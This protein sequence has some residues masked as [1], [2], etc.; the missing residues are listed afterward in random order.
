MIVLLGRGDHPTDGVRDYCRLLGQALAARGYELHVVRMPWPQTGWFR[1]LG[2][3]WGESER[4]NRQQVL[5]QYTAL[6]WSRRGFPLRLLTVLGLLR[7]RRIRTA[8]VFHDPEPY[9]GRR[10]VDRM[11]RF[12]Q[13][14]VMRSGYRF[15]DK[16]IITVAPER[17]SWLPLSHS[18]AAFI[19]V[20]SNIP[21][22]PASH[23]GAGDGDEAKTISVFGISGGKSVDDEVHDIAFVTKAAATLLPGIR[24]ITLG[25]GSEESEQRLRTAL[26][27]SGVDYRALGILS[28][29]SVADSLANSD[30]SLFV[31][32]PISTQRGSA[33][34]SIAC[35]LPV[36]A[37][38]DKGLDTPLAEAG[39]IGVRNGDR[40][41]LL[42]AT[43]RVLTDHRLRRELRQRNRLA[44]D[45]HFSWEA[46]AARFAQVLE[47]VERAVSDTPE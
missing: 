27:G 11:R 25:R 21:A 19:P 7:M 17:I 33:L 42:E 24:L 16:S 4:W 38:S 36:V 39:V 18:K 1:S 2:W 47:H 13:R 46:I 9:E 10:L 34:A 22:I 30:V 45:A 43:I 12:C 23:R 37:Y 3:L 40:E 44:Y 15:A 41:A 29:K 28:A 26:Q 20:G 32:G 6:A 14:C 31:R 5:I 35:G 8:I